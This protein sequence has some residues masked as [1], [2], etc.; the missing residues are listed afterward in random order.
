[1]AIHIKSF[2]VKQSLD[3]KLQRGRGGGAS[4]PP[5]VL[6]LP[7]KHNRNRVKDTS[8]KFESHVCNKCYYISM[9]I[10]ELKNIA[11]LKK[12]KVKSVYHRFVL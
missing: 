1:M 6:R 11:I 3:R 12:V 5:L 4:L 2:I 10:Y 8:Y 7:Q 9:M